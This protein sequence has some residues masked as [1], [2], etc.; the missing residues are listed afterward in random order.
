MDKEKIYQKAYSNGLTNKALFELS[1]GE[2]FDFIFMPGFSTKENVTEFSG[3]GV[4]MDV[5]SKN[6]KKIG[7]SVDM[8]SVKNEGTS[9]N[10]KIPLTVATIE[11]MI[12]TVGNSSYILP[13]VN[14]QEAIKPKKEEIIVGPE[15]NEMILI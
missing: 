3:R 10:V 12:I 1:N 7:G 13:T 6:I 2:I 14:I 15:G 11:G 9:I 8:E 5:V 4:G